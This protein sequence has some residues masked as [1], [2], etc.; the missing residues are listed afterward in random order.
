MKR[1]TFN[2]NDFLYGFD[3]TITDNPD[4]IDDEVKRYKTF[5]SHIEEPL[6]ND[7][8]RYVSNHSLVTDNEK[9]RSFILPCHYPIL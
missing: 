9:V 7:V 6:L 5:L 8:V 2:L 3:K 1:I 4:M